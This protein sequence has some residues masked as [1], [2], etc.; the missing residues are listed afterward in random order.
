[1][2]IFLTGEIQVGKTTIINKTLKQ[3]KK[4]YGG[5]KTYFGPDRGAEDRLLYMNRADE[6]NLFTT[7][8]GIAVFKKDGFPQADTTKFNTY[9]VELIR[10][11]KATNK[12]MLVMD[13]CGNL[14]CDALS[15]QNEILKSLSDDHPILGVI[16][17]SSSGWTDRIRAHS[18]VTLIMVTRD[19][20]DKLPHLLIK[21]YLQSRYFNSLR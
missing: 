8:H 4:S 18:K 6:P 1:M 10:R 19:N 9:G 16:K 7:D 11:A 3:L 13:E 15:F 21:H 12:A 14:E 5:F 20:R 17:L 2:H